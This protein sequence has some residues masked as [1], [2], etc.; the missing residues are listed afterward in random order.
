MPTPLSL[1]DCSV[2]PGNG[3]P[4]AS[5]SS[6]PASRRSHSNP[7]PVASSTRRV[8]SASSGPVPSPGMKVTRCAT[9]R[10]LPHAARRARARGSG[11]IGHMAK[12]ERR[13]G[14]ATHEVFNQSTPLEN[15]NVFGE[16][17]ALVEALRREGGEW[18][19]DRALAIG[20]IAGQARTL[21]WGAEANE[22]PPTLRTHDRFGSRIDEV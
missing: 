9:R 18:A 4:C 8:A 10:I 16:D 3:L 6:M 5:Y 20:E 12:V 1:I 11:K 15:Y 21:R 13:P 7:T 22:N 19:E 17:R 2:G 14:D